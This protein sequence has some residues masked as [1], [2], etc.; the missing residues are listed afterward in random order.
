MFTREVLF[1]MNLLTLAGFLLMGIGLT[2]NR[3]QKVRTPVAF[4]L[5]GVGTVLV[6]FGLYVATPASP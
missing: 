5:M 3:Q 2:L 1:G 4:A 6:F